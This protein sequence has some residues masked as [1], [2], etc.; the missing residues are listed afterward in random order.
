VILE[1]QE[2]WVLLKLMMLKVLTKLWLITVP[3]IWVD[4]LELNKHKVNKKEHNLLD[5]KLKHSLPILI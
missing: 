4:I 1:D 3:N 2:E 5:N